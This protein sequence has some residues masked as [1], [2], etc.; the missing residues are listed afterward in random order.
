V[1]GLDDTGLSPSARAL[2]DAAR[3]DIAPDAAAV[4]RMR[5]GVAAKVGGGLLAGSLAAK[6]GL[7]AVLATASIG[8]IVYAT[9]SDAPAPRSPAT[10][11]ATAPPAR[12]DAVSP[13]QPQAPALVTLEAPAPSAQP[14]IELSREVELVDTAMAAL[15]AD[16][17][18]QA[19]AI[20]ATYAKETRGTGQL[21]EDAA[22]VEVEATC[23]LDGS[24]AH[25]AL[26]AFDARYPHSAQRARVTT[27]CTK[28]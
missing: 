21:A 19:L 23:A 15:A 20:I 4:R 17:A 10:P 18:K 3:P 12:H 11:I 26:A 28:H 6:I 7:A 25:R 13:S 16:D 5:A 22:A 2:L 14:A 27:A 9:R 1:S 24:A 8:A